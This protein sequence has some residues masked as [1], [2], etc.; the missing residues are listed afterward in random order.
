[1]EETQNTTVEK[2]Y[3]IQPITRENAGKDRV[4]HAEAVS[5]IESA[6]AVCA[7]TIYQNVRE[8]NAATF[9]GEG[10]LQELRER[11]SGLDEITVL[12]NGELSPSQTL[13]I[14]AALDNRKVIDRTT[15]ILDIFAKNAKIAFF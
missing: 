5:L 14:S 6:G 11:L 2:I 1:M 3:I 12:F 7:G 15:L 8:I 13:N 9:V 10:K 4:L